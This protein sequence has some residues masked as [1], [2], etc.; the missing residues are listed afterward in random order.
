MGGRAWE[1]KVLVEEQLEGK[2]IGIVAWRCRGR[3]RGQSPRSHGR[4]P[5]GSVVGRRQ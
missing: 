3:R 2:S 5:S 4:K 1:G